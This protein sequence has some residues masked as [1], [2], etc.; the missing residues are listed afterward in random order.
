MTPETAAYLKAL[1]EWYAAEVKNA[2]D[3][4][5]TASNDPGNGPPPKPPVKQ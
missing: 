2:L 4:Q 3:P 5:V 1:T